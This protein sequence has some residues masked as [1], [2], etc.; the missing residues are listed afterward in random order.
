M[1]FHK[2]SEKIIVEYAKYTFVKLM[3]AFVGAPRRD[4]PLESEIAC[5][6]QKRVIIYY[7]L[8]L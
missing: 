7:K 1:N 2:L 4:C 5:C 8:R 3:R 6:E